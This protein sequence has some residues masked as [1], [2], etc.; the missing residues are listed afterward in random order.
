VARHGEGFAVLIADFRPETLAWVGSGTTLNAS[1]D[2][3]QLL[4]EALVALSTRPLRIDGHPI[5]L[6]ARVGICTDRAACA[7]GA[8]M[9]AEAVGGERITDGPQGRHS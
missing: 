1:T 7:D 6:R 5:A 3:V 4:G 2:G 9:L 8:A